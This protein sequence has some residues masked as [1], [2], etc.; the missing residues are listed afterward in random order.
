MKVSDLIAKLED[1]DPDAEV[2][3][4]VQPE[5]AF[6]H[7]VEDCVEVTPSLD[8]L[9]WGIFY[10]MGDDEEF[11]EAERNTRMSAYDKYTNVKYDIDRNLKDGAEMEITGVRFGALYKGEEIDATKAEEL[12]MDQQ[13]VVFISE[14]G[15]DCYLPEA[16]AETL[17]WSRR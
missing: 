7:S 12:E 14:A 16:A 5:W 11:E 2:K 8:G 6:Q 15:Q 3:L 4:A 1:F 13:S 9:V 17:G 10:E